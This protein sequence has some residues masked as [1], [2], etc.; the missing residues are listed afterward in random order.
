MSE[1]IKKE[2]KGYIKSDYSGLRLWVIYDET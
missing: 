2:L 1:E